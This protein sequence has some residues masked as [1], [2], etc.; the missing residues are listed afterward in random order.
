M[1]KRRIEI[2][3]KGKSASRRNQSCGLLALLAVFAFLASSVLT[4]ALAPLRD[5]KDTALLE[6]AKAACAA[7]NFP[8]FLRAFASS[9]IVRNAYTAEEWQLAE[10]RIEAD[11]RRQT[12]SRTML[13]LSSHR[14]P[15]SFEEGRF[16]LAPA[17]GALGPSNGLNE[18]RLQYLS[19]CRIIGQT[20]VRWSV[21]RGRMASQGHENARHHGY[22]GEVFFVGDGACWKLIRVR[23]IFEP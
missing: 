16:V 7:P 5:P 11:G 13:R 4:Y 21:D 9:L 6:E 3:L 17:T 1:Q 18:T 22:R 23:A 15:I 12:T 2:D 20:V 14:F 10:T 8:R 19:P